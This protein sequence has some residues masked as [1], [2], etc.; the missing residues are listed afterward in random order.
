MGD[1]VDTGRVQSKYDASSLEGTAPAPGAEYQVSARAEQAGR[2]G[3]RYIDSG[4]ETR[5]RLSTGCTT[6]PW[7]DLPRQWASLQLLCAMVT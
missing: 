3:D 7:V 6:D 5:H 1:N 4:W 2:V